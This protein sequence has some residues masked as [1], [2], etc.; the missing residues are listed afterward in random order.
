MEILH[1]TCLNND[2]EIHSFWVLVCDLDLGEPCLG[3]LGK[4]EE[5]GK[6]EKQE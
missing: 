2:P 6:Q 1:I 3:G 5:W 4:Y